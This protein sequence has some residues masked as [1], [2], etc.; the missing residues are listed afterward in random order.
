MG[1]GYLGEGV[2]RYWLRETL[3]EVWSRAWCFSL[4]VGVGRMRVTLPVWVI[5][6]EQRE[7]EFM[8]SLWGW[9]DSAIRSALE[10]ANHV[11]LSGIQETPDAEDADSR[12]E[13]SWE[14]T[15]TR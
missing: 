11:H 2:N 15:W 4:V 13:I 14:E 9:F 3:P 7:W 8:T 12:L 5:W 1:V 6:Q 10:A